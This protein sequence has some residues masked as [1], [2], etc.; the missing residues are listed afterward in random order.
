MTMGGTGDILAGLVAGLSTQLSSFEAAYI[1]A[2][3]IG[4]ACD[5][6]YK[7]KESYNYR[8]SDIISKLGEIL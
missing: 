6:L 7:Q 5:E 3:I 2:F 1:A 8:V 4:L